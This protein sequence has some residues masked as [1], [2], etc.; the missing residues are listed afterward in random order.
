[1]SESERARLEDGITR[2]EGCRMTLPTRE[3]IDFFFANEPVEDLADATEFASSS[4]VSGR[5]MRREEVDDCRMTLPTRERMDFLGNDEDC[6]E[7][8]EFV[9]E[10]TE[11]TVDGREIGRKDDDRRAALPKRGRRVFFFGDGSDEDRTED[12][13]VASESERGVGCETERRA[14]RVEERKGFLIIEI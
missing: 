6:T 9:S 2:I 3:I 4:G 1:M 8:I 11:S 10:S 5:E 14:S 12:S 7:V 13:E